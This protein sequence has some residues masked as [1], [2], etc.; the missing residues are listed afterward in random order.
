MSYWNTQLRTAQLVKLELA[1]NNSKNN[2]LFVTYV[3][4]KNW[5]LDSWIR[6]SWFK[7]K[8]AFFEITMR[9]L[10]QARLN[11]GA[12]KFRSKEVDKGEAKKK[13]KKFDSI[14][15]EY[16]SPSK[17]PK[18]SLLYSSWLLALR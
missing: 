6:T 18:V 5:F 9:V 7:L 3:K 8:K 17:I 4:G 14:T 2:N 10:S 12:D 15:F 11:A 16:I 1:N 13:T